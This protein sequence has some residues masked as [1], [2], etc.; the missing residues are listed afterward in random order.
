MI[1]IAALCFTLFSMSKAQIADESHFAQANNPLA[2]IK[3]FNVHNYYAPVV[4][5]SEQK[6]NTLWF[7][8]AQ[9]VGRIL[10]RASLPVNTVPESE[11]SYKSGLGDFNLLAA[12]LFS[13]PESPV[14]FGFG[15]SFSAPTAT[16]EI[17]GQGKWQVGAGAVVFINKNPM[18]QHGALVTWQISV[19]GD[20]D[21]DDVNMLTAQPFF[22][23]QLGKGTYLRS[24]ATWSFDLDNGNYNVPLGSGIG[25]VVKIN[26][27]VFNIFVE[28]QYSVLHHAEFQP[29]VQIFSGFNIQF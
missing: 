24:A 27:N 9:P 14:Q 28:A 21:R 22:M 18:F 15:P 6:M 25:K 17:L 23:W 8:Y 19:A 2:H 1:L 16:E 4:F 11:T 26:N 20:E 5:G 10:L 12:Y 3:A 13:K 7:R 29:Q